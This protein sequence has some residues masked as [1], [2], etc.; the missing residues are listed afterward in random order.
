MNAEIGNTNGKYK[1]MKNTE[2][3]R[4]N[5]M[6]YQSHKCS[7][8]ELPRRTEIPERND[9]CKSNY[10][11]EIWSMDVNLLK[12]MQIKSFIRSETKLYYLHDICR[13]HP[14]PLLVT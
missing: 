8:P 9:H 11:N 12:R 10:S 2:H 3:L 1:Q 6:K 5:E 14:Q 4:V 13:T 7:K